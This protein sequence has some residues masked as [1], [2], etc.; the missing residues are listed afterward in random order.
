MKSLLLLGVALLALA[1]GPPAAFAQEDFTLEPVTLDI[2]GINAVVPEGWQPAGPGLFARAQSPE[3]GLL[4]AVQAAPLRVDGLMQALLPQ[5][6]LTEA[7]EPV[8]E[9][10]TD[11]LTW[12]LYQ[13][14]VPVPD[15]MIR[16]D[17]G[18]AQGAGTSYVV[19]MQSL[20][21]EYDALHEH[22]FLPVIESVTPISA[23]SEPESGQPFVPEAVTFPGGGEDVV[24]SGTLTLPEGDGPFPA[25]VLVSGSGP[26]DRDETITGTAMKPFALLAEGITPAGVAVLRYDDRGTGES[27]G[28]FNSAVTADFAADAAAA[29]AYL[30]TRD[31]IA[32]DQIGV[33][34]HSEG[35]LVAASL[36]AQDL[37]AFIISLAGPGVTGMDVLLL[38][39]RRIMEADGV[40]EEIIQAQVNMLTA[41]FPLV[42]AGDNGA[43]V[44]ATRA[45]ALELFAALDE[46]TQAQVGP[47]GQFAEATVQQAMAQMATPWFI[48]FLES[49]PAADWAQTTVPVLAIFG[50]L[51][52]QVDAEQN[53]PAVEAALAE[54]G[55]DDA[56]VVVLPGANHL[57]QAATTGSVS[58]YS[59]LPGTFTPDLIPTILNWL[60]AQGITAS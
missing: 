36:G 56:T 41:A 38:Q 33:F 31:D 34:G 14:D 40:S 27:T 7:P 18:L 37:P 12:T 51:D 39:N 13:V 5:I 55:N 20:P 1:A 47:A 45:G 52:V 54:A 57:F 9:L 16:V 48:S 59:T 11:H 26:Q 32:P 28:D 29:L 46:A 58:E 25:I 23:E 35:G 2:F 49:D 44:E 8:A 6:G 15:G 22:L 19:L 3:D 30:A 60:A 50:G 10:T 24:L 21:D 17:L 43:A 53:A 4:L 42:I